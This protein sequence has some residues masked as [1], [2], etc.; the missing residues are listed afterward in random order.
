MGPVGSVA[1]FALWQ[2]SGCLFCVRNPALK[3]AVVR[4]LRV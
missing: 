2:R 1:A 4:A 3:E